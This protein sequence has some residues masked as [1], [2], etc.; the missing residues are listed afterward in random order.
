MLLFSC[1]FLQANPIEKA[2]W[3]LGQ[4]S[5]ASPGRQLLETWEKLDDST[6][7]GSGY[8]IKGADSTLL[9]SIRLEQ[10]NGRLFYVPLVK[11]Q[12]NEKPVR[13][14]LTRANAQQLVFENPAHDFPQQITYTRISKDSLLA[15]ISGI[16][17]G[18]TKS[19]RFPMRRIP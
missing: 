9:E 6:F 14:A 18:A 7:A 17:Q 16:V 19:R 8:L 3:L 13:F 10:R 5:A 11:G 2:D 4:W 1:C 15:E 12:N